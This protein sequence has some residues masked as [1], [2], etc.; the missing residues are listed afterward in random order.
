M[1][2]PL[3]DCLGQMPVLDGYEAT[4]R[5]RAR[6]TANSQPRVPVLAVTANAMPEERAKCAEAGFDDFLPKPLKP[7]DLYAGILRN[8]A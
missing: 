5:L 1:A 3:P 8:L 2:G 6:E 4:R 7:A